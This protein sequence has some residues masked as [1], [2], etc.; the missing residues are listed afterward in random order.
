MAKCGF[1]NVIKPTGMTSSDVVCA[2]KK[3]I[4]EKKVGHLGT[5]DPAASGVLPIA[6]GKAAKFF[7]YFLKKDKV[8]V[9]D[10]KFG[11]L[12]DTLDSFGKIIETNDIVIKKEQLE[13][14]LLHFVGK[15]KQVPPLYSAVKVNGKKACDLARNGEIVE[16][17][18]RVIEIYSIELLSEI[19]V[20]TFRFR[21]HCSAG[22]YIRTLFND[23]AAKLGTIA[24]TPVII[25]EKS[26]S[27]NTKNAVTLDEFRNNPS[28]IAVEQ[29]FTNCKIIDISDVVLS[30]KLLNGVKI[31]K[32][33]CFN[34]FDLS[35]NE[36]FF[37]RIDNKLVGMYR[38]LGEKLDCIVFL[39]ENN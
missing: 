13:S 28:L 18:E 2:V 33:D 38:F 27:F 6:V 37:I 4:G 30:K 8:Y 24:T 19:D 7:D 23:I 14:V 16:L 31:N 5:L 12:T 3:I 1:V 39:S 34:K 9:A 22:T 11:V 36:E 32:N 26:G 15:I 25:R 35:E 17:K 21:V 29:L 20:N 10:V